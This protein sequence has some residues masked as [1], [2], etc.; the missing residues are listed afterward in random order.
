MYSKSEQSLGRLRRAAVYF[1]TK[2]KSPRAELCDAC[3]CR[4]SILKRPCGDRRG[5]HSCVSKTFREG[6]EVNIK[7]RHFARPGGRGQSRERDRTLRGEKTSAFKLQQEVIAVKVT[8]L[9][10]NTND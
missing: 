3:R 7:V 2:V 5:N 4:E 1:C 8:Q 9:K 10:L 6:F